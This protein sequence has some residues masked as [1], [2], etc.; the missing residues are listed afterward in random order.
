MTRQFE[1]NV[2]VT[3]AAKGIGKVISHHYAEKGAHVWLVD[4]REEDGIK[5]QKIIEDKAQKATFVHVDVANA[6]KIEEFFEKLSSMGVMVDT[7]INNAGVS[8]FTPLEELDLNEWDRIINT[9]VRSAWLFAKL[10][11]ELMKRGSSIINIASTRAT[12]SEPGS[13]AYAASKGAM[14]A[15]T[16]AL[17]ASLSPQGIRVNAISPGWIETEEYDQLRDVDH[18]QH[19]SNRVGKPEDIARAC[20][21][22]SN[23]ENDFIT[24]ENLVIDGGM[25]RKMIYNH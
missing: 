13:E 6:E 4:I 1:E 5:L 14:V 11:A 3:G 16:H 8:S 24:G 9:N 25:T 19:W 15:L 22:L 7:I 17:A 2:I 23:Q 21:F 20:L 10:G 18:D 12:M